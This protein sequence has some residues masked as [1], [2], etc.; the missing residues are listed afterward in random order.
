MT[1]RADV[2]RFAILGSGLGAWLTALVLRDQLTSSKFSIYVIG[3]GSR[4]QGPEFVSSLSPSAPRLQAAE[5]LVDR[6]CATYSLGT[7]HSGWDT[8]QSTWF[9]P[10][11]DI[12]AGIGSVSF[13][14]LVQRLRARGKQVRL[15]DFALAA[16][17][18][19][20][21]RFAR[22][23]TADRS[24][25]SSCRWGI[26]LEAETAGK[27]L[28]Q[29]ALD[30]GVQ[31]SRGE[32]ATLQRADDGTVRAISTLADETIEVDMVIDCSNDSSLLARH[33]AWSDWTPWLPSD[34][35]MRA[36]RPNPGIAQPFR[37]TV[38][39]RSGWTQFL[40]L[41][42]SEQATTY[43]HQAHDQSHALASL[44]EAGYD[45]ADV[46]CEALRP[47][48]RVSPW[49]SNCLLLGRS[50]VGL[51]PIGLSELDLLLG[52]L[53]RWVGLL[54]ATR[55]METEAREYNRR[56]GEYLDRCRDFA[57]AHFVLND[58]RDQPFWAECREMVP[59][60][61]LQYRMDLYRSRGRIV[62]F[63]EEP[64]DETA[65]I[66]LF[67]ACGVRPRTYNPVAD[68]LGIEMIEG[69]L[70]NI[71]RVMLECVGNMPTLEAYLAAQ[72]QG[73][74]NSE[75]KQGAHERKN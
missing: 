43:F 64:V 22:A 67:D 25:L 74:R 21:C 8:E 50:A 13:H 23:D 28:R 29:L 69:H 3:A 10:F 56:V 4:E 20:A 5:E 44:Q 2:R 19:Q 54:P 48:R 17:A 70:Q 36:A 55:D 12:G 34:Q 30:K 63:D 39:H 73:F 40:G 7:A 72:N 68:G 38:A 14:H 1:Q 46:N 52:Q 41:P 27:V 31:E 9:Q 18:A 47:G 32:V 45:V 16:L 59:P 61:T 15:V 65:W 66:A 57:S 26:H 49:F 75:Q 11:S 42:G 62:G 24:V 6:G 53:E 71:R 60:D 37:H 33:G 51:E 35:C 58:R